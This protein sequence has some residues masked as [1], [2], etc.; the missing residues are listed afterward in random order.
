MNKWLTITLF[1]VSAC[2]SYD[3]IICGQKMIWGDYSNNRD[4]CAALD[5]CRR[6]THL[7]MKNDTVIEFIST[8]DELKSICLT[9]DDVAGCYWG[10]ID[11]T[12]DNKIYL[13]Y[14]YDIVE[15]TLFCHEKTHEALEEGSHEGHYEWKLIEKGYGEQNG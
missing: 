6:I 5:K 15:D 11:F 4:V 10:A 14:D 13:Y 2:S 12:S 3:E 9:N 7:E 8:P 1:F